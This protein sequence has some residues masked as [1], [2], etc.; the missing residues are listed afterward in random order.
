M[1]ALLTC[2]AT[3]LC[4]CALC[5]GC[6]CFGSLVSATLGQ[7]ARM[8]H[9]LLYISIFVLAVVLGN[10]YQ[11]HLVGTSTFTVAYYVKIPNSL[12]IQTL[13]AGCDPLYLHQCVAN[14]VIYR[15]SCALTFFF[16]IMA[17]IAT[18]SDG[19]NKGMWGLKVI[20]VFGAF[21]A[22]WYG[23]N[24]FFSGFA[25]VARVVSFL[26]LLVQGLL[27]L[28]IAHD[29][30]DITMQKAEQEEVQSGGSSSVWKLSYI[31]LALG[32]LAAGIAGLS[33]LF[34]VP[35][36][37][38]CH[39]GMTVVVVGLLVSI[40]QLV[41]SALNSVNRGVLTPCIM[42]AYATFSV[43]YALLSC[44]DVQ[45]NPSA[46]LSGSN[47]K[48]T[49]LGIVVALSLFI[50]LFCVVNGARILQIFSPS[51][52]GV[53]ETSYGGYGTNNPTRTDGSLDDVLTGEKPKAK[54]AE[55]GHTMDRDGEEEPISATSTNVPNSSGP[56]KER[57]FF[58][59]LM[60][61]ASCYGGMV[62]TS[63]GRTN[64]SP[65][66]V[67]DYSAAGA[68]SMWL[69]LTSLWL[70]FLMYYKALHL[71]YQIEANK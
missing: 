47:A 40:T 4:E 23:N 68:E 30:H 63:W 18:L 67:G 31:V 6:S 49:A 8:A 71:S 5:M 53:L 55:I 32:F 10:T 16:M 21:I 17:V 38:G 58:H 51:G 59:V 48:Q 57:M 20:G 19:I 39:T 33:Y 36:Y 35:G 61:L 29:A 1:G 60:T 9:L 41:I 46:I 12:N 3:N 2:A 54:A 7:A 24:D 44:P 52:Q 25:E 22:F 14:Q 37:T 50:L 45:C 66:S 42:F 34:A 56:S 62:L 43:W 70:F 27:M 13:T 64:G 65:E 69:K 26:W 28:D 11:D 15:A